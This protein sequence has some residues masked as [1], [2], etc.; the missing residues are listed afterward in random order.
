MSPALRKD[1]DQ[2]WISLSQVMDQTIDRN[3]LGSE[4]IDSL[5]DYL[6]RFSSKGLASFK[7]EWQ[8]RSCKSSSIF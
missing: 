1:I 6:E 2:R 7:Q 3:A 4:I 5:I 8:K